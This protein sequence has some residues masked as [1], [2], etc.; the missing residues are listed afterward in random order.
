MANEVNIDP[1]FMKYDKAEVE[2]I[3]ERADEM[4]VVAKEEDVRGIVADYDPANYDPD[5]S[6]SSSSE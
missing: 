5:D 2:E 6:S 4:L 1:R 3:L